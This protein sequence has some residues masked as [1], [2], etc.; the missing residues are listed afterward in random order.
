LFQKQVR[1][2]ALASSALFHA[3]FHELTVCRGCVAAQ[4]EQH[5]AYASAVLFPFY[6]F[7]CLRFS[8]VAVL[9]ERSR[10]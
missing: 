6:F 4:E 8:C 1:G 9:A 7:F 2:I 10:A 3:G 5:L